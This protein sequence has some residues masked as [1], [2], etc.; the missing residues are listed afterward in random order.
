VMVTIAEA[1]EPPTAIVATD[2]FLGSAESLPLVAVM[3][4]GVLLVTAGA[5]KTPSL[6]IVPVLASQRTAVFGVPLM[7][8]VNCNCCSD[9]TVALSGVMEMTLDELAEGLAEVALCD[10]MLH[11]TVKPVRQS[12]SGSTTK[13]AMS[14]LSSY[15]LL[16][17]LKRLTSHI[18][19]YLGTELGDH[20]S[21]PYT[22]L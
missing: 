14:F 22:A 15:L 18:W 1:R 5:V 6:E 12:K 17:T 13:C 10:A 20:R 19:D 3:T 21:S 4:A 16:A 2:S 9:M 7:R 11:A 8:A